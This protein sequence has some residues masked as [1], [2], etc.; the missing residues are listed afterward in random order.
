M[1]GARILN[2]VFRYCRWKW[3]LLVSFLFFCWRRLEARKRRFFRGSVLYPPQKEYDFIIVGSGSA[4]SALA[5]D[6]AKGLPHAS[7]LLLEAGGEDVNKFIHIPATA[8]LTQIKKENMNWAY[9]T[10]PQPHTRGRVH[11]WPRGK[12]LGGSR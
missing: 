9:K 5:H 8:F 11:L 2:F 3:V 4:G 12:V 1:N 10:V 6:L 7:V